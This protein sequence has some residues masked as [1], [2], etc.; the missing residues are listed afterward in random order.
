MAVDLGTANTL[1]YV[2]GK[3][4]L[5]GGVP[6]TRRGRVVILGGGDSGSVI[7]RSS[8]RRTPVTL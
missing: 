3:G 2:R 8:D 7:W 4:V 5:L 1:V 6:G